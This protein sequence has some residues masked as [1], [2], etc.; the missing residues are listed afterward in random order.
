MNADEAKEGEENDGT[1]K[2]KDDQKPPML[3]LECYD[4]QNSQFSFVRE[5]YLYKNE[6]YEPFIDSK[7][8]IDFIKESSF[9]TNG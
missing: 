3:V 1:D 7:N 6:D 2:K 5:I 9:A 8:S 4:P